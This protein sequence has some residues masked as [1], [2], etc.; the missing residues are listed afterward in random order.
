MAASR[1]LNGFGTE[2]NK[3]EPILA[4]T[5]YFVYFVYME[6]GTIQPSVSRID[7]AGLTAS[8]QGLLRKIS[9]L[10]AE[11]HHP[12]L[13]GRRGEKIFLPQAIYELLLHALRQIQEGKV[14][15]LV[16]EDQEVTT[17]AAANFLGVSRPFLVKLL[18]TGKIPY[19]MVGSHRRVTFKDLL[20]F[21]RKRGLARKA[22]LSKLTRT[23]EAAGVY[24]RIV[25][26]DAG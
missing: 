20:A 13:V 3:R 10:L 25:E 17:Q 19:R 26:E 16:P 6:T 8:D 21:A 1:R 14:V 23:A 9:L 7:P 22:A 4:K 24:D 12:A 11:E 2:R 5:P 18:E 15:T